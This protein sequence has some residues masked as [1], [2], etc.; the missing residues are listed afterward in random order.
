MPS[1]LYNCVMESSVTTLLETYRPSSATVELVN[2]TPVVLL[3][4]VSGA[5]K[6]TIKHQ[7][8]QTGRYHHIVSHTTREPRNNGGVMEQ[9]GVEYHF[10][11]RSVAVHMI[12]VGAFVEA[13][14]YGTN[15][16][17]TSVAE[18]EQ[19]NG[20]GRIALT[21]I[22]VQ[23]VSEYK[24]ISSKVIAIFVLPPSYEEWQRRLYA[25]YLPGEVDPADIMKRMQTAIT[26]LEEAL[27]K[28]YY[29]F[30]INDDL[31]EAVHAV[32]SIAHNNDQFNQ[33]DSTVRA[34]AEKLL[35]DLRQAV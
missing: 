29:H 5:G 10:V 26:E 19:A 4:G 14:Q 9:D 3:V 13:K 21:D 7:L 20:E 23:G 8:L 25:R 30:V 33:V 1:D 27:E 11:D 35:E 2:E 32:D 12:E 17:G 31:N 6:D 16:Y 22:E 18:I 34:Q 15:I 24:A 28:P